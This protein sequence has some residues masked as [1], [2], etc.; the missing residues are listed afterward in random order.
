MIEGDPVVSLVVHQRLLPFTLE[1]APPTTTFCVLPV[2]KQCIHRPN[3]P[4]IPNDFSSFKTTPKST[5]LK[6][7]AKSRYNTFTSSPLS[8]PLSI[9]L[10][11]DSSWLSVERPVLKPCCESFRVASTFYTFEKVS[12]VPLYLW[13]K[14]IFQRYQRYFKGIF[15]YFYMYFSFEEKVAGVLF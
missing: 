12:K 14:G 1:L 11:C 13:K 2:K 9:L 8:I 4:L 15:V 5:L 7:L 6:A 3:F 10:K